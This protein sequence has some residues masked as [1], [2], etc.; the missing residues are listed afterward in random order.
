MAEWSKAPESGSS[1]SYL[2]R[3]GEGSNPSV[4]IFGL[5]LWFFLH[6]TAY[7]AQGPGYIDKLQVTALSVERA[8]S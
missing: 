3:K 5:F 7:M 8:A 1:V 6:P 2:V 4:V